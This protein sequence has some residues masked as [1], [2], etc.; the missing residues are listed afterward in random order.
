MI[1]HVFEGSVQFSNGGFVVFHATSD[2][3]LVKVSGC[4]NFGGSISVDISKLPK[5]IST[6]TL[7][8]FNCSTGKFDHVDIESL[9]SSGLHYLE[10]SLVL[11]LKNDDCQNGDSIPFLWVL[12]I[13]IGLIGITIIVIVVYSILKSRKEKRVDVMISVSGKL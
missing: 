2:T 1:S 13:F 3:P 12:W 4:V 8:T 10:N 5:N 9:C 11:D 6:I 7:M